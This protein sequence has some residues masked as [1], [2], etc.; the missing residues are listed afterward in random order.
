MVLSCEG[1]ET[2]GKSDEADAEGAVVDYGLDGV[3]WLEAFGSVPE[4][5]HQKGELLHK[6]GFLE[7]ETVAELTGRSFKYG[8]KA[9]E[10]GGDA[11]VGVAYA[12]T[13]DCD[14]HDVH[15]GEAQV[16]ASD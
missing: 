5:R 2:F 8:I 6:R 11:L 7:V 16:A 3:V 4:L 9:L 14:A 13:F 10:E 1:N 12:H 15:G